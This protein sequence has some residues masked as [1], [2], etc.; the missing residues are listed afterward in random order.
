ME[1][2]TRK[3]FE[4]L[5]AL[6]LIKNGINKNYRII[7]KNKG[8]KRKKYWVAPEKRILNYINNSEK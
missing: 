3:Q 4:E 6:G 1:Q 2:V 7:N 5:Q 8:S